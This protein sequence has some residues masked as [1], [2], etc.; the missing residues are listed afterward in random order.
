MKIKTK[1]NIT[2]IVGIIVTSIITLDRH[3]RP[4]E[5]TR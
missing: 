1:I 2:S 3:C 5:I 4:E